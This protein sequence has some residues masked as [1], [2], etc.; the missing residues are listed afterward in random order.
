MRNLAILAGAL[1]FTLA[2]PVAALAQHRTSAAE[3]AA[4][5]VKI[6][7][8]S[9]VVTNRQVAWRWQDKAGLERSKSRFLERHGS[10]P[11]LRTLVHLWH[12]RAYEAMKRWQAFDVRAT[13]FETSSWD[14]VAACESGGNWQTNTGNG[15]Y[16][17]LQFTQ[18]TWIANGGGRYASRAD[19]ATREQQISVA[20][21][22]S[23]SNWP[24][25]G[26]RYG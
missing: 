1:A 17:G 26:S 23:L 18:S 21:G 10:V 6:T 7:L 4:A 24:V 19:L 14:R 13:A 8:R 11:Y 22:L 9:Q 12:D 20:S 2:T 15:F 16:G 25:C 5:I 3:D